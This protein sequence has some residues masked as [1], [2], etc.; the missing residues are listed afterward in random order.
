MGWMEL[1]IRWY[2][3]DAYVEPDGRWLVVIMV[4]AL[5][6][7]GVVVVVVVVVDILVVVYGVNCVSLFVLIVVLVGCDNGYKL[8]VWLRFGLIM[9]R[10]HD[11]VIV[12][13]NYYYVMRMMMMQKKK[14]KKNEKRVVVVSIVDMKLGKL[15]YVTQQKIESELD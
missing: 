1:V 13:L 9:L 8:T 2:L 12:E 5:V 7:A 3:F 6:G 4:V 10:F 14:K 15:H 11:G